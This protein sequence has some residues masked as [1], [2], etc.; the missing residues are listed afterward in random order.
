MT[1]K[2]PNCMSTNVDLYMGGQFGKYQC[3]DCGY[4][5]VFIIEEDD[6]NT[7]KK[8]KTFGGEKMAVVNP[9]I[10]HMAEVRAK[11]KGKSFKE[12]AK[13]AKETYKK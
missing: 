8:I 13:I 4:I 5:G 11:N 1:K 12:I 9:W 10:K 2:C 3:N 6:E 7:D